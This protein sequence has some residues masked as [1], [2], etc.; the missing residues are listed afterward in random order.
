MGSACFPPSHGGTGLAPN[1]QEPAAD[2]AVATPASPTTMATI[3]VPRWAR[4]LGEGRL[5][6]LDQALAEESHL[7]H[8]PLGRA[9]VKVGCTTREP[10]CCG[11]KSAQWQG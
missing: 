5:G 2:R 7:R 4:K 3:S 10:A 6:D 1:H 9:V 8:A 11:G